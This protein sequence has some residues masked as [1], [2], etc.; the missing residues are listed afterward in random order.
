MVRF[1]KFAA[2]D[3]AVVVRLVHGES[4]ALQNFFSLSSLA[5]PATAGSP[6]RLVPLNAEGHAA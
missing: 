5:S 1:D 3:L 4:V 6:G 2:E